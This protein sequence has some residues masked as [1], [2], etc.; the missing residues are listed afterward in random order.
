MR[1]LGSTSLAVR[2]AAVAGV[3]ALGLAVAP[4]I[5]HGAAQAWSIAGVWKGPPGTLT[6]TQ[7]GGRLDGSFT[8][9]F[10]CTDTYSVTGTIAD[11]TVR[12]SLTRAGGDQMPCAGT[13]TLNGTVDPSGKALVL[14]LVN[15]HQGS[16]A[17]PYTGLATKIP[18]PP[19]AATPKP[20]TTTKPAATVSGKTTS[21]PV[22]VTCYGQS[23]LCAQSFV[24]NIQVG[25]S[26]VTT[27]FFTSGSYCSQA[28]FRLNV[29]GVQ[30]QISGWLGANQ[31]TP[32]FAFEKNA[33]NYQVRVRAEGRT[34][35]CNKGWLT[36]W[37]GTLK[38]TV[39]PR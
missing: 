15:P 2:L 14:A 8:M 12:L 28:R 32:A 7:S 22:S 35:G 11:T 39:Y 26:T 19:P 27:Q 29:G 23:Q 31:A 3:V 5:A 17:M 36:H 1:S 16:P 24:V 13:Q 37:D 34:G 18:D 4:G 9:A 10:G 25:R 6:L 21:Y 38:V 30:E 20:A 33:G